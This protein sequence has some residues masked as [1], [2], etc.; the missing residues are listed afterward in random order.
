MPVLVKHWLKGK[1]IKAT[2][3]QCQVWVVVGL[4]PHPHT[5]RFLKISVYS[6]SAVYLF[7]QIEGH[8]YSKT[9]AYVQRYAYVFSQNC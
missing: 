2:L 9:V 4:C 3:S 5:R 6:S 7:K 8:L 1:A